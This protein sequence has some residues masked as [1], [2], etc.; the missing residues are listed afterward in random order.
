M[1]TWDFPPS[2]TGGT[3]AHVV[4]SSR[5][6][7]AA[8]HDVVVLT[9]A[10]R[11][12][13]AAVER[14][15]PVRVFRADVDL[16]HVP[17]ERY[18]GLT[19][20]A[21][22]A[23]V[24]LVTDADSPLRGWIPDIVHGHDWKIGWAADTLS[25]H[26][27]VPFVLTMHGTE[28]VRH[29]G[30]LPL[31]EPTDVNAI[32]WWLAFR[33]DR[34]IAST[35][36]MVEQLVSGFELGPEQV[37]R[38][39]NGIE[40]DLWDGHDRHAERGPLVV[41]WGRVQYE[42]GFQ[43]LTRAM[44]ILRGRMPEVTCTIAGRGSYLPELQTRIDVEG[45]SDLIAL[46]GFLRDDELRDLVHRAGCVV[47]PSLYEPFGIVAL[48]A[49]AAGAPLIVA[50]TGGLA[51]LLADTDAGL[52]FEPGNPEALAHCIERVLREPELARQLTE[53]AKV[54]IEQRY[55]WNAIAASIVH[56]Y[57]SAIALRHG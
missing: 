41:S 54:L 9:I 33:A 12:V 36:F 4:G 44:S 22:H 3:A 13:D 10:A 46:P 57:D 11:G 20:S 8:G 49:L 40:P 43:V 35:R 27:D 21:N 32:E 7:A 15:G 26:H 31:G 47:I 16:P 23:I 25:R 1:L 53:S 17:E 24:Q 50:R 37:V 28:R 51:E 18:L 39:P 56:V 5:A 48:E 2:E 34:V 52:T 45:I 14:S 55:A 19:A 42:K 38:I 30:N 6:L 29:G